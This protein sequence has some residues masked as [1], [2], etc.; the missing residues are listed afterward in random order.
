MELSCSNCLE[1]TVVLKSLHTLG[2]FASQ[3]S[4]KTQHKKEN[5]EIIPVQ[6]FAYI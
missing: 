3:S 4:N 5:K 2:E 1:Y 6:K